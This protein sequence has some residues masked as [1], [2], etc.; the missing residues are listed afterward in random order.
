MARTAQMAKVGKRNVELSNLEKVLYPEDHIIKAQ[1]IEYYLR[2]APTILR[3]LKGRALSLVRFPD[4]IDGETF[5]QKNRPEWAPEWIESVKLGDDRKQ[6]EYVVATEPASLVWLAN[7]ACLELHQIHAYRPHFDKPDYFVCDIDPPEGFNFADVVAI[8]LELRAHLEEYG[9][10]PFAKTTGKKGVHVVVPI[11][12]SRS[13]DE[14]FEAARDATQPFVDA[15]KDETTLHMSKERRK[16]RVLIDIYRNRP[17]QTIVA[18]YSLR[19][20][21][22]APVSM[23]LDWDDL[24]EVTDPTRFNVLN[25]ADKVIADGDPWEALAAF[26]VRLHTDRSAGSGG[27]RAVRPSRTKKTPEQ[28]DEY[29]RKRSFSHTPEPSPGMLDGEGN[30]F[31]VHRHHASHLHYDLRL[32][33]EG[34]LRSWAVPKGLPPRPGIMRLAVE[35][36]DH[37]IEYLKFEGEIP[38]GQYGGGMMWIYALGRYETLKQKKNGFYFRLQSKEINA[39]YRIHQTRGKEWLLERVDEPQIDWLQDKVEPM[40]ASQEREVPAGDYWY[41]LKWDGI[42]ALVSVD[43]G[44]LKIR[45]RNQRDITAQ[46][47]ELVIPEEAFRVSSGLFDGEIVCFDA[48]GHPDF[49]RVV[50]RLHH[51]SEAAIKRAAERHPAYCYLFDCLYLD[52]RPLI[53][54]PLARRRDWLEDAVRRHQPY[55]VSEIMLDGKVFFEAVRDMGLEGIVAKDP[56][57][58]YQPG[59]RTQ[60]WIKV[61]VRQTEDCVVVG[62]TAGKGDRSGLFGALQVAVE[63]EDG[64]VYRGKVGTGFGVQLMKEIFAELK[65]RP[66]VERPVA[67]K[68]ADDAETTWIEPEL[69]CEVQYASITKNGTFREPVFVRLLND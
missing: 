67:E 69:S 63:T 27:R 5:F 39:E 51:T 55:R 22:G 46:F 38:K 15:R 11:E 2:I 17:S 64:L 31:V 54:D 47:P 56:D 33:H 62:Y 41:E 28:L 14:V 48:E 45:S 42:R 44:E 53:R 3:H 43:E 66:V 16:G 40:L 10:R 12:P 34:A 61:K 60:S 8:A 30:A 58:A 29:T 23:P 20:A 18:P 49:K 32:E 59:K 26:A 35:V 50:S 1:V 24:R 13:F 52:G 65:K 37:P 36:E 9:Y 57:S 19:G 7:L 68:P 4:G 25:V 21:V 6:I